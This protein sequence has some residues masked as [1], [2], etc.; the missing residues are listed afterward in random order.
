MAKGNASYY[1]DDIGKTIYA[2]NKT[3][4]GTITNIVYKWCAGCQSHGPIYS[5]KWDDGTRTYPCPA[6]CKINPDGTIEI[7]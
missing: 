2:R 3:E 1:T 4:K 7:E 6:G 5:V